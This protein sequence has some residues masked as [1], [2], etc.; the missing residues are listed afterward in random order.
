MDFSVRILL[1]DPLTLRGMA[2]TPEEFALAHS[3]HVRGSCY[4]I[5]GSY[6]FCYKSHAKIDFSA[7]P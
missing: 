3:A 5:R 1:Q 4:R 6:T 2:A 7:P